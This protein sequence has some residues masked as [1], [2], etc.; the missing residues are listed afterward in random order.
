MYT[1]ITGVNGFIGSNLSSSLKE[2]EI[3]TVSR[4]DP[5]NLQLYNRNK[6]ISLEDIGNDEITLV[7]L[8]TFFSKENQD[9]QKVTSANISYGIDLLKLISGFNLK[10]I[11]YTN[12]M[13]NYYK[14]DFLRELHYT[15]TKME[16]SKVLFNFSRNQNIA[17]EEIFLDNTFGISDKR[18]KVLPI[19]IHHIKE[20]LGNPIQNPENNINLMHICEV[21]KR[22]KLAINSNSSSSTSF[23]GTKSINL[24]SIYLFLNNYFLKNNKSDVHLTY[25]NN[26]YLLG[27]PD[28]DYLGL[29]IKNIENRLIEYIDKWI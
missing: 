19:I 29:E 14:D 22:I 20:N 11:I 2:S 26:D 17:Y 12:T 9:D 25:K 27:F 18:K 7:H 10:K 24:N 15:K 1:I 21:I 4:K 23:I 28:I 3:L 5:K 13:Y 16:F 8:A 6:A